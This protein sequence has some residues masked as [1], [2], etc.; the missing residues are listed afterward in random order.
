MR[1][2]LTSLVAF[3][4]LLI[5]A[6]ASR[7]AD[8]Q[9]SYY[10][11]VKPLLTQTCAACHKPEKSKGDLDLTVVSLILK[12]GKHGAA[13]TP[14]DPGKSKLIE[15][16][17]GDDPDMPKDADPLTP[18]QVSLLSRWVQQGA[19]DDTPAPGSTH[20]DPPIYLAAPVI[21]AMAYSPDGSTL[22]VSGWHE[23]LLVRSDGS[24]LIGRLTGECPRIES[25]VF[26]ADGK[27]LGVAGGAPAEFG[28]VQIWDV[29]SQKATHTFQPS[30]D[31]LYGLSFAPDGKSVAFGGADKS[32][33]QIQIEDGKLLLDLKAHSD[34]VM[35]TAFS[36]DGK[37]LVTA[38][39]DRAAKLM[40]V[41]SG[42]FIDDINNP[43]EPIICL[44]RHP[45]EELILYGGAWAMR[46]FTRSP[47]TRAGRPDGTIQIF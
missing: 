28:Q 42:R 39:R 43:L 25:L 26:T 17:S 47:T 3:A 29:A 45:K 18:A 38:G 31:S 19:R 32:A 1:C 33:R 37:Q 20:I 21:S 34:W 15:M 2:L 35:G 27:T 36:I 41:A 44:T 46:G 16:V 23:V 9:V 10:R 6:S 4:L 30:A 7:G 14:G 5:S 24:G 8:D 22:A 11:Q 40:D 12:G 13:I